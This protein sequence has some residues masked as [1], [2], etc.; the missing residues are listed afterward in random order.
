LW[1]TGEKHFI[2]PDKF[3]MVSLQSLLSEFPFF[4]WL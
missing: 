3:I 2:L 4:P 1:C